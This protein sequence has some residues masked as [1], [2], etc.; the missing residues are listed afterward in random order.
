MDL[1][2]R[3]RSGAVVSSAVA[4]I[5]SDGTRPVVWGLGETVE[6]ARIDAI[7]RLDDCAWAAEREPAEYADDTIVRYEDVTDEQRA[8]IVAG[9]IDCADLGIA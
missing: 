5:G 7:E 8:R 1:R 2:S 6:A 9:E 4:A 3:S